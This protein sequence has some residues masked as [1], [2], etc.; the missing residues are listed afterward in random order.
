[1]QVFE[2]EYPRF[3]PRFYLRHLYVNFKKK[4]GGGLFRDLMMTTAK[5]TYYEAHD[6]KMAQIKEVNLDAFDWLTFIPKHKWCNYAFP[7]YSK[8]DVVMNNLNESFN[9]TIL[10]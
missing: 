4:F 8:C 2:E 6:A 3:E 5:A 10:L 1:M 9:V 7:F